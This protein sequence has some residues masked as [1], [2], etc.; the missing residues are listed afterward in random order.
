MHYGDD[1]GLLARVLRRSERSVKDWLSGAS[2]V[3]WWVPEYLRLRQLEHAHTVYQMT[4]RQTLARL[5]VVKGCTIVDA[6]TRFK[7]PPAPIPESLPAEIFTLRA[8]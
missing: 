7:P 3:P 4:G 5:G 8:G 1:I 2:K 6:G